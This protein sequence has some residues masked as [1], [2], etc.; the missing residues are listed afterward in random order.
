MRHFSTEMN[1]ALRDDPK[2]RAHYEE[3]TMLNRISDPAEQAGAVVFLLSDYSSC[4][5]FIVANSGG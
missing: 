4:K 2:L 1:Q 5:L 3:K